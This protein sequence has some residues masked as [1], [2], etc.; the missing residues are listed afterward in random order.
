MNQ[1]YVTALPI[2][3]ITFSQF[4]IVCDEADVQKEWF[5]GLDSPVNAHLLL[6]SKM[7]QIWLNY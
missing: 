1:E 6:G 3:H 4:E 5:R 7:Q 2:S